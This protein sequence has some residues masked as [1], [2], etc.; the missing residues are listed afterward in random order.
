MAHLQVLALTSSSIQQLLYSSCYLILR[1]QDHFILLTQL[2]KPVSWI[3]QGREGCHLDAHQLEGMYQENITLLQWRTDPRKVAKVT[4]R[5]WAGWMEDNHVNREQ[6]SQRKQLISSSELCSAA[7][8]SC[9]SRMYCIS[10]FQ[11]QFLF[12]VI[13]AKL[14]S[15]MAFP[16]PPSFLPQNFLCHVFFVFMFLLVWVGFLMYKTFQFIL[17]FFFFFV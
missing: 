2:T 6:P 5:S 15:F 11:Q 8:Q 10:S 1:G 16:T 3:S 4:S 9:Y 14:E 7:E 17:G 13:L 12:I